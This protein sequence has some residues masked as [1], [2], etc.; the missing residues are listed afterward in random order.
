MS[1]SLSPGGAGTEV[2]RVRLPGRSSDEFNRDLLIEF[3]DL[4]N[5]VWFTIRK[6]P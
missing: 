1:D 3:G 2:G 6:S 4:I 5:H